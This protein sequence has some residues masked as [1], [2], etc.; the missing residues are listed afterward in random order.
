M[1]TTARGYARLLMNLSAKAIVT[2]G[3]RDTV[4]GVL[5]WA[6]ATDKNV[7]KYSDVYQK[8]GYTT[9]QFTAAPI[10]KGWGT[11]ESREVRHLAETL[12]SV[13]INPSNRLIFHCFS[14]NGFLTLTSLD[15]QYPHLK[16]FEKCD[17]L[18][19]DSCP[20][21]FSGFSVRNLVSHA[22][23]M[24]HVY[25]G[26][27]K[28]KNFLTSNAYRFYKRLE[29][30]K[31][32]YQLLRD[33]FMVTSGISR[34]EDASPYHYALNHPCLPPII[35]SVFSDAD[36]VCSA[37]QIDLFNTLAA[38]RTDKRRE[39]STVRLTDSAHVEH[40]R[41]YPKL[42]LQKMEEFMQKVEKHRNGGMAKL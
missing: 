30:A 16:L 22:L 1:A 36:A 18:F 35:T 27:I 37:S 19:L 5:G 12:D 38:Q 32:G 34:L 8:K 11:K 42:Y 14:M 40:F 39:V 33:H 23:V 9:V 26:L 21:S 10:I 28:N 24:D 25:D 3:K 17:G 20:A 6:G 31:F 7:A 4:V 2:H 41:K 15:A 13:L 29:T